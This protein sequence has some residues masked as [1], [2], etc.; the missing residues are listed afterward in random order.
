MSKKNI[1][2]HE[3]ALLFRLPDFDFNAIPP[4][5]M[6]EIAKK[7]QDWAQGI[8]SQD[9]MA[10]NGLRLSM[11]GKVLRPGGVI[12]DGPFVEIKEKLGSF[13]VIKADSLDEATTLAHGCPAI[14]QGGSVEIRPVYGS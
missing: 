6:K 12:T 5:K 13:I 9:K 7:W 3:Y 4:E 10:S 2:M 8:S 14:D 1:H 11:E